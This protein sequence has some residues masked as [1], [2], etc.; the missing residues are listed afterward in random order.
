[1]LKTS[2][3]RF[4]SLLLAVCFCVMFAVTAYAVTPYYINK[5]DPTCEL[6][7][8]NGKAVM[9]SSVYAASNVTKLEMS[10]VLQ[11]KSGSTYVDVPNT[12]SSTRTFNKASGSINDTVSFSGSGTYRV[13]MTCTVTSP[14]GT[15]THYAYSKDLT[16][17]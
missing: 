7:N 12:T 17:S 16:I 6:T 9:Y 4:L 15:D 10:Q 3:G 11:K 13:K 1:M 2:K 5:I 14:N 8:P